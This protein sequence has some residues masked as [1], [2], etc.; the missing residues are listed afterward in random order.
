M[1]HCLLKRIYIQQTSQGAVPD[2][3]ILL[4]VLVSTGDTFSVVTLS[5]VSGKF[6]KKE[7]SLSPELQNKSTHY[8][9]LHKKKHFVPE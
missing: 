1:A 4:C 8:K 6:R 3:W 9:T 5:R 7:D 2:L